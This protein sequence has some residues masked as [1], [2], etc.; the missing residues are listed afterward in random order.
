MPKQKSIGMLPSELAR[1]AD[2]SVRANF[3]ATKK[4]TV[5]L[6]VIVNTAGSAHRIKSRGGKPVT[7][8]AKTDVR[9][10]TQAA[11]K[12]VVRGAVRGIPEGF[13][14]IVEDGSAPH[15]M[16]ARGNRITR[17]GRVVSGRY[18]KTQTLRK[19]GEGHAFSDLKPL[20]NRATGGNFISQWV[21]HPGH[22]PQGK[23]WEQAMAR[24][25]TGVPEI[26]HRIVGERLVDVWTQ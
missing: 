26:H 20:S 5:R 16:T 15:L 21:M 12:V 25:T 24:A 22:G 18:T 7:L 8:S 17:S 10:F 3:E 2:A 13:W 1:L 9:G 23:P 4:A 6:G 11:G 14:R 19:F